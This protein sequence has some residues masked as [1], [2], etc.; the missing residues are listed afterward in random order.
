VGF[1]CCLP[2]MSVTFVVW[3]FGWWGK[4]YGNAGVHA[5]CDVKCACRDSKKQQ[6][7]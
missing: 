4:D 2:A 7:S 3:G 6:Q 1:A 5:C